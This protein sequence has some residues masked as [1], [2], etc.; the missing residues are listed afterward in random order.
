MADPKKS[1]KKRYNYEAIDFRRRFTNRK[2]VAGLKEIADDKLITAQELCM[3]Y[4][5]EGLKI[6]LV[7][8]EIRKRKR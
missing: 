5:Q 8:K 7:K 4:I 6:D 3:K 1:T 2:F